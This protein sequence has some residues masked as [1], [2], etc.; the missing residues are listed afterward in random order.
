MPPCPHGRAACAIPCNRATSRSA[1]SRENGRTRGHSGPPPRP[2]GLQR[3]YLRTLLR[4]RPLHVKGFLVQGLGVIEVALR[5]GHAGTRF[6][7]RLLCGLL[8]GGHGQ[9]PPRLVLQ[10]VPGL[11]QHPHVLLRRGGVDDAVQV[12]E[13]LGRGT[14]ASSALG[15]L[16]GEAG[17]V[18]LGARDV[19]LADI[20]ELLPGM[21]LETVMALL[22][23]VLS[24][25]TTSPTASLWPPAGAPNRAWS[26]QGVVGEHDCP[27]SAA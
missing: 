12:A 5:P 26:P 9:P 20:A 1:A 19:D 13:L 18:R 23:V 3:Q 7:Q 14:R 22:A 2:G 8:A 16:R 4:C 27:D 17:L 21:L 11:L 6:S 24:P 10:L 25:P 15:L